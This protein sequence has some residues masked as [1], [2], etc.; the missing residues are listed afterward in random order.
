[1]LFRSLQNMQLSVKL[2]ATNINVNFN[3]T[4]FL[5]NLTDTIKSEVLS[6]VQ[7]EIPNIKTNNA[8]QSYRDT[9]T[10]A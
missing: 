4:S 6:A 10:L 8:G 1:M 7:R 2:D 9:S 5:A 3:G